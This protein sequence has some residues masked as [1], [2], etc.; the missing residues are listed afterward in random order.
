[1]LA[2]ITIL[3]SET[4][5]TVNVK[6]SDIRGSGTDANVC[7]ILFGVN[8]NTDTLKLKDSGTHRDKFERN[9]SDIF[10]FSLLSLGDLTKIRIW[11]D[12]AG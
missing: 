8:G 4:N 2:L 7:I 6:T 11:H 3:L 12:N 5:Y 10:S 1:M 9:Q